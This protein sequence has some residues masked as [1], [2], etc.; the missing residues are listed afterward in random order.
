[1]CLIA[2]EETFCREQ[3]RKREKEIREENSM[4]QCSGYC[5][6]CLFTVSLLIL[7]FKPLMFFLLLSSLQETTFSWEI[8]FL[9][10]FTKLNS[11][12][13]L[14]QLSPCSTHLWS[15]NTFQIFCFINWKI[16]ALQFC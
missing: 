3:K 5:S 4:N 9:V 14:N 10:N 12:E 7:Q 6:L 11:S 16:I 2:L 13:L 15:K 1:M 8:P